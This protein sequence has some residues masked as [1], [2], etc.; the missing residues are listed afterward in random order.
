MPHRY[1]IKKWIRLKRVIKKLAR[2]HNSSHDLAMG[3]AIGFFVGMLPIMGIQMVVAAAIAAIFRVS[4]IAAVLPVWISNPL[5]FIPLY[6]FNYWLGNV[7]TGLGPNH[8]EYR[9]VL[10]KVVELTNTAGFFDGIIEGTKL[11]GSLGRDAVYSLCIGSVIVGII[12]AIISYPVCMK[13]INILRHRRARKRFAR[14][15]RVSEIIR[16]D[17]KVDLSVDNSEDDMG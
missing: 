5:T 10:R 7:L 8:E 16:R 11:F 9:E 6:G 2:S 14:H 13:L 1:V 4:K 3:A 17:S 15:E 12:S